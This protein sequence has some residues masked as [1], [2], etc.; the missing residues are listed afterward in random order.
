MKFSVKIFPILFV[1]FFVSFQCKGAFSSSDKNTAVSNIVSGSL[2]EKKEGIGW[3]EKVLESIHHMD[4][5]EN[6]KKNYLK[7]VLEGISTLSVKNNMSGV[8]E[9]T[10]RYCN[11]VVKVINDSAKQDAVGECFDALMTIIEK[12]KDTKNFVIKKN[13]I[14]LFKN[15]IS[16]TIQD[17]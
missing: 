14:E 13:F 7:F 17:N 12:L 1:C 10:I 15:I 5:K 8:E 11:E 2:E 6:T 9:E 16:N 4:L 3:F